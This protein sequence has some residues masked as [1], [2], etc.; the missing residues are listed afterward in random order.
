MIAPRRMSMYLG[1]TPAKSMPPAT[2]LPQTFWN[3]IANVKARARKKTPARA[4]D[5]PFPSGRLLVLSQCGATSTLTIH[6]N[7]QKI[8]RIPVYLSIDE[9][10]RSGCD[11]TTQRYK[12]TDDP[13]HR[14]DSKHEATLAVGVAREV[15]LVSHTG[16]LL[17]NGLI[18]TSHHEPR[19]TPSRFR[20][21]V[22]ALVED[23]PDAL[24]FGERPYHHCQH[25]NATANARD[26]ERFL[27]SFRSDE[28]ERYRN[29]PEDDEPDHL[30]SSGRHAVWQCVWQA[31]E[32]R[33]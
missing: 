21:H 28:K 18:Q 5:E 25:C 12:D 14:H 11:Q 20:R 30:I 17:A 26:E 7:H 33:P 32:R 10:T 13:L 9:L 15:A 24:R 1:K 8:G 16:C 3:R 23:G 29:N 2:A 22:F 19:D 31:T 6:D 27:K 4:P